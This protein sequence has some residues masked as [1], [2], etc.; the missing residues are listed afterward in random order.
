MEADIFS[1]EAFRYRRRV[2]AFSIRSFVMSC[3]KLIPVLF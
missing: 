3:I 2:R 1:M